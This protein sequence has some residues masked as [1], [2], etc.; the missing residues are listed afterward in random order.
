MTKTTKKVF[1]GSRCLRIGMKLGKIESSLENAAASMAAGNKARALD[2]LETLIKNAD[3]L[4][5]M[6]RA[7]T[8]SDLVRKSE[9]FQKKLSSMTRIEP[10]SSSLEKTFNPVFVSAKRAIKEVKKLCG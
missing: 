10:L 4:R 8:L 3:A 1:K 7:K 9:A 5:P 2:H 6:A